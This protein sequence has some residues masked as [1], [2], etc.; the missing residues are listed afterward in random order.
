MQQERPMSGKIQS[1]FI[2]L[3]IASRHLPSSP[4]S[5]AYFCHPFRVRCD[6][7]VWQPIWTT[8]WPAA[9]VE[10]CSIRRIPA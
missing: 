8:A 3:T 5:M 1:D 6:T 7:G 9:T 2:I 10:F 4:R